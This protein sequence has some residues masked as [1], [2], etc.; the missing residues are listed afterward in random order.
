MRGV[1][2]GSSAFVEAAWVWKH[3]LGGAM[4]QAGVLAAAGLHALDHHVERLADDHDN[5]RRFAERVATIPGIVL[6]PAEVETNL[7]F[8]KVEATGLTAE[9]IAAR[10][11]ESGIRIGVEGE[12]RMRAVTHLDVD[13]A[14]VAEAA[15]AFAGAV[16]G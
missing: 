1:L 9:T 4:R 8:M 11:A 13:E 15:D 12:F 10:T 16:S 2:A 3:R 7:V 14:D 6:D 5:A